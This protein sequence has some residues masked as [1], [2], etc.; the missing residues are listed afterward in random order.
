MRVLIIANE[1]AGVRAVRAIAKSDVD[2]Y[3][4]MTYGEFDQISSVGK[5]ADY[6][7]LTT[8]NGELARSPQFAE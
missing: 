8:L 7:G 6:L 1:A 4:V 3:A 5:V 2:I